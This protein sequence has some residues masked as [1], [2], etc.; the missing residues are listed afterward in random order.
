MREF[1]RLN[2]PE[3]IKLAKMRYDLLDDTPAK[4]HAAH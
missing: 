2:A 4:T 1:A 3:L